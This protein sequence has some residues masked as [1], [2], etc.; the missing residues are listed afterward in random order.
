MKIF[1]V[2][3]YFCVPQITT[4]LFKNLSQ[5]VS[6]ENAGWTSKPGEVTEREESKQRLSAFHI[7]NQFLS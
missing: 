4:F 3:I 1:E 2:K 6:P 7:T 5:S